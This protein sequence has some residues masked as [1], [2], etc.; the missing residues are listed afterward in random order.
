VGKGKYSSSNT[1]PKGKSLFA[2]GG[3]S[4]G[5][6]VCSGLLKKG[7]NSDEYLMRT[8]PLARR[9]GFPPAAPIKLQAERTRPSKNQHLLKIFGRRRPAEFEEFGRTKSRKIFDFHG[10]R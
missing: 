2:E 8:T 9:L 6:A 10:A 4:F 3:K 7:Q 5:V 1:N